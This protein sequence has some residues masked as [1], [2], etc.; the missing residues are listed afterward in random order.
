MGVV[1]WEFLTPFCTGRVELG[2]EQHIVQVAN[3]HAALVEVLGD[4]PLV[5]LVVGTFSDMPGTAPRPRRWRPASRPPPS[6]SPVPT[7]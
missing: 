4:V 2:I 6:R 5:E 3:A 7:S 1:L